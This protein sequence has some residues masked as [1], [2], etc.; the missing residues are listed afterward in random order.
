MVAWPVSFRAPS[1]CTNRARR[2]E[3][4]PRCAAQ[5]ERVNR[6]RAVGGG[7]TR[8]LSSFS[9]TFRSRRSQEC[10]QRSLV[11]G[12][13]RAGWVGSGAAISQGLSAPAAAGATL[14]YAGSQG[15]ARRRRRPARAT[16]PQAPLC[17]SGTWLPAS[18]LGRCCTSASHR[19]TPAD[20][21]VGWC[22][23][24]LLTGAPRY[25]HPQ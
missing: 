12:A 25:R 19:R 20:R 2:S 22:T 5:P 16:L 8:N 17:R 14:C 11:Q 1:S 6:R 18:Q 4:V 21:P 3:C 7:E 10:R 9:L 13:A 15:D 23:R 24:S